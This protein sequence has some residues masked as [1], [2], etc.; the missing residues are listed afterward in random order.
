M[1]E[2]T[3]E[4][5]DV[6]VRFPVFPFATFRLHTDCAYGN[7]DAKRPIIVFKLIESHIQ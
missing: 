7:Q 4:A 1:G 3:T 6:G 2:H 5:R